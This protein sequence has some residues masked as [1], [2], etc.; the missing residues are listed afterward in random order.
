MRELSDL[1][2]EHGRA[3]IPVT[4]FSL[5]S[6]DPKLVERFADAGADRFIFGLPPAPAEHVLP[7]L[8]RCADIAKVAA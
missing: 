1:A 6:H 7:I 8:A 3:P 2:R 5:S 4:I